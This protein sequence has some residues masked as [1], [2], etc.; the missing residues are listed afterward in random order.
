M[1]AAA[2]P[3]F[4]SIFEISRNEY[5][6]YIAQLLTYILILIKCEHLVKQKKKTRSIL[7]VYQFSGIVIYSAGLFRLVVQS[8]RLLR[9]DRL[10]HGNDTYKYTCNAASWRFRTPL[11]PVAQGIQSNEVSTDQSNFFINI[12]YVHPTLQDYAINIM[13]RYDTSISL[14]KKKLNFNVQDK[15]W[16][17]LSFSLQILEITVEFSGLFTELDTIDRLAVASAFPFHRDLR[18]SGHAGRCEAS[19]MNVDVANAL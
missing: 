16:A 17:A 4:F 9:R 1:A 5:W 10:D 19:V 18:S 12:I 6:R 14:K 11:R 7:G 15:Q 13:S 3:P 8:F 2:F